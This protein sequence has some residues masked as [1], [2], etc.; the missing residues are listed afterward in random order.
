[1]RKTLRYL[2]IT[3]SVICGI[4]C[5]LLVVLWV[6]SY[7][8]VDAIAYR[9]SPPSVYFAY[10]DDGV[11]RFG[12]DSDSN[13][14]SY[15]PFETILLHSESWAGYSSEVF[16]VWPFGKVIRGF[17]DR[18]WDRGQ[19]PYWFVV[20]ISATLSAAPWLRW[21]FGLRTLLIVITLLAVVLGAFV[22]SMR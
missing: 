5:L 2:R 1:M 20:L 8:W 12:K 19:V 4:L 9:A 7:K 15:G 22:I 13:W 17:R 11:I 21:R 3:F 18:L 6:R 16:D 10:S 14:Q